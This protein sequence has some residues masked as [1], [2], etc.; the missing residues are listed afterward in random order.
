[1][2]PLAPERRGRARASVAYPV[3]VS[4]RRGRILARGRTTD[5]SQSGLF[6]VVTAPKGSIKASQVEVE[7]S[8]PKT[9]FRGGARET[10]R[11]VRYLVHVVRR[12]EFGQMYGLALDFIEK[13]D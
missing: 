11:K 4:D 5:L 2:K 13:L 7:I 1:M 10:P 6:V 8:I 9:R 3:T 12:E